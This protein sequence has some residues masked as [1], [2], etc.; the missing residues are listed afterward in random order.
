MEFKWEIKG[1]NREEIKKALDYFCEEINKKIEEVQNKKPINFMGF[2]IDPQML[3]IV[4]IYEEQGDKFILKIHAPIPNSFSFLFWGH[5]RNATK[6]LKKYFE[7]L[8][9]NVEVKKI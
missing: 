8:G 9:L 6:N 7:K 1:E 3:L 5:L 2:T 4:P